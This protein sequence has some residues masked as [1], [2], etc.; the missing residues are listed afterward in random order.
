MATGGNIANVNQTQSYGARSIT[1]VN[2]G[3]NYNTPNIDSGLKW[4]PDNIIIN[5]D[6][7]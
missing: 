4:L 7:R 6:Q 3:V 5:L 2:P 1:V